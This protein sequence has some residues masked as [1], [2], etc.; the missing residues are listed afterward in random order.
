MI[1]PIKKA[2]L[3]LF[4]FY[5]AAISPHKGGPCCRF[6]PSCSAYGREAVEKYGVLRGLSLALR[7]FLKCHPFHPG[8][9]DP[10][11]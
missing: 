1:N 6:Y 9:Y 11:P 10:V 3:F 2:I 5:E 7:R 8:A 4:W